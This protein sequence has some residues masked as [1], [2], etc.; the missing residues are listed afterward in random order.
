METRSQ[1]NQYIIISVVLLIMSIGLSIFTYFCLIDSRVMEIKDLNSKLGVL[2]FEKSQSASVSY[3]ISK[4][5]EE[6]NK[7]NIYFITR[8]TL[9]AFIEELESLAKRAGVSLALGEPSFQKDKAGK[10]DKYVK[11]SLRAEGDFNK[12]FKFLTLM[13]SLPYKIRVVTT[14]LN[15]PSSPASKGVVWSMDMVFDLVSYVE[16]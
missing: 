6:R 2:R 10:S 1:V 8:D 4:T 7:L 15:Q 11:F 12:V 3:V 13:E 9:G 16:N 5:K 14:N